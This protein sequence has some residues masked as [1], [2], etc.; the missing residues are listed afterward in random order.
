M[1]LDVLG[2]NDDLLNPY[3]ESTYVGH[4]FFC[5]SEEEARQRIEER[6]VGVIDE[7]MVVKIRVDTSMVDG[8]KLRE[9]ELLET[10]DLSP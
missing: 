4:A 10:V 1:Y 9:W 2:E 7:P 6:Y 3:N 8:Y 5:T